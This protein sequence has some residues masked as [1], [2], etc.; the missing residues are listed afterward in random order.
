MPYA[1]PAVNREYQRD[2]YAKWSKINSRTKIAVYGLRYRQRHPERILF[3]AARKRA[4]NRGLEFSIYMEDVVIP[5]VCPVLGIPIFTDFSTDNEKKKNKPNSPSLDRIDPNKGY[6]PDNIRVI[7][8][9]ANQLKSNATV[10]EMRLI[11]AD[12]E[13]SE[14]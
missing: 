7:S 14:R 3:M 5:E 10:K 2:Y 1:D 11:L 4:S 6:V 12:L 8:W 9:R 13:A